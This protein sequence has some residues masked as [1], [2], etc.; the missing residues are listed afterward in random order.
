MNTGNT[1]AGWGGLL[2][3]TNLLRTLVITGGVGLHAVSIYVVATVMPVVVSEIGGLAFFS[4]TSTLYVVGSLTSASSVPLLMARLGPRGAY[5]LAC[6]LFAI[7][8][9]ICSLSTTMPMLLAGRLIQGL[10]GGMLPAL[11]YGLIRRIFPAELHARAIVVIG[12]VWGIAALAGPAVGGLFAQYATWRAAFWVDVPIAITFVLAS[13]AILPRGGEGGPAPGIP[14]ARL[15][16][17]AAAAIAVSTGG[18]SAR[19]LYAALGL[20]VAIACLAATLRIDRTATRRMFPTGAFDWR[21]PFGAASAS[22]GLLNLSAAPCTFLPFMLQKAHGVPPLAA[23]YISATYALTW[24]AT[25]FVTASAAGQ[26]A[27]ALMLAGPATM[28]AGLLLI[29]ATLPAGHLAFVII[30]QGLLGVG[31]GFVWAHLGAMMMSV[32]APADRE[33][34]GPFIT[35]TQTLTTV[36]GSALA[37]LVANLAGL[38]TATTTAELGHTTAWLFGTLAIVP[39]AACWAAWKMLRLTRDQSVSRLP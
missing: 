14:G 24:T 20:I 21:T 31:I 3:G 11:G 39:L 27:R 38:P 29:G 22:L 10:G 15:A 17:L 35:T 25:S 8:S 32:A 13:A 18:A 37:G 16:L 23:G 36:F 1:T 4:W 28:L 19:P 5:R 6:L 30:G 12:S 26:T 7:G 2:R 9:L 34:A 33:M